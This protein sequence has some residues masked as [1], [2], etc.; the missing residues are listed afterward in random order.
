VQI[1]TANYA[2]PLISIKILEGLEH[3]LTQQGIA[4]VRSLIGSLRMEPC[5]T[6]SETR[7]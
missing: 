4:T 2:D 7:A 5:L 3:F 6:R 1:G